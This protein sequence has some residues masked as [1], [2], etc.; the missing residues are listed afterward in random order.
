MAPRGPEPRR[1]LVDVT[2]TLEVGV[3]YDP[4]GTVVVDQVDV[5]WNRLKIGLAYWQ[6]SERRTNIGVDHDIRSYLERNLPR[7]LELRHRPKKQ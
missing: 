6:P 3:T 5:D 4:R 1:L 2:L 7:D